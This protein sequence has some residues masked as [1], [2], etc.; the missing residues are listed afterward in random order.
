[1]KKH[2]VK[3]MNFRWRSGCFKNYLKF[4]Y[5]KMFKMKI[6]K[7]IGIDNINM[8]SSNQSTEKKNKRALPTIALMGIL[9]VFLFYTTFLAM[10]LQPGIVPDEPYRY[11]VSRYFSQTWGIPQDVPIAVEY[12]DNL[13]RNPFLG[14]WLFGRIIQ[15]E[16][17]VAPGSTA[18]QQLVW[19]RLVNSLFAL[20][21]LIVTYFIA[22]ALIKNPWLQ[23]LPVFL[24]A[25]TLM[26][27]FL[28]GGVSYDNP[29]N[30]AC[31][32]GILFLVRVLN[33]KDFLQNSLGWLIA[34]SIATLIKYSVLPL[35]AIT[36][37]IWVVFIV[38]NPGSLKSV[39]PKTWPQYLLI[40][41]M[42]LLVLGNVWLYG[43]N[44]IKFHSVLPNC[45]DTYSDEICQQ[46]HWIARRNEIGLP[47]KLSIRQ[48][49][50]LGYPEP[51]R[52]FFDVWAKEMF[53]KIFGILGHKV[54]FPIVISYFQ[55]AF[56]WLALLSSRYIRKPSYRSINLFLLVAAYAAVLLYLNYN[57]ELEYGFKHVALQGRYFFP[58]ISLAMVMVGMLL[59]KVDNKIVR[60][61]TILALILLFLYGS[62]IRF[63]WYQDSVFM[64]WFV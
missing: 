8:A 42:L 9:A 63:F 32:L 57:T 26:F 55:I 50:E 61:L 29:T 41:V 18:F 19:L 37:V 2:C 33:G 64:D 11:E 52:Y 5:N 17:W 15:F 59:E 16:N 21:T 56:L 30:L 43:G 24:L 25:N 20:G 4:I 44:L 10:H 22:K 14:Y 39:K 40:S 47:Q 35:L 49:V 48:A 54:Y 53:S 60:R 38:R 6:G 28:A 58:V 34:L 23:V 45:T 46:S 3:G 36:F 1:M 13:S 27:A 7:Q 51:I 12:G 31:A 62:P